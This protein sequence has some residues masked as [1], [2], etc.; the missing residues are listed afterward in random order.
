MKKLIIT[1]AVLFVA[2]T[3]TYASQFGGMDAGALNSQYMKDLRLH[4]AVSRAKDKNAIIT[5]KAE[6]D[7]E[8]TVNADL[9]SIVFINNKAVST[10]KLLS[11]VGNKINKPMTAENISQ[12]RKD[13]MKYYQSLGYYS[14]IATVNSENA[15]EGELVIQIDEGS[16]NSITIQ[17]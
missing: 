15:A 14:A 4:E 5:K 10:D 13:I 12:I 7:T 17:E 3:I 11:L 6:P 2:Q 16:L 9:K 8:Q 1:L